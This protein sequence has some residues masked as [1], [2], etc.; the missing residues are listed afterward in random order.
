MANPTHPRLRSLLHGKWDARI[1][2]AA[3]GAMMS[4][5]SSEAP[6]I[7]YA[8]RRLGRAAVSLARKRPGFRIAGMRIPPASGI[9]PDISGKPLRWR[10][11]TGIRAPFLETQGAARPHTT[12]W[13]LLKQPDKHELTRRGAV[14]C[15]VH[16]HSLA[17]ER[18]TANIAM[19]RMQTRQFLP[20]CWLQPSHRDLEPTMLPHTALEPSPA[21]P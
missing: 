4:S 16:H 2:L 14:N 7:S 19:Y 15:K 12:P 20:R 9:Q 3:E 5:H 10:K 18:S 11:S 8:L 21:A 6:T 17:S 13:G 1:L